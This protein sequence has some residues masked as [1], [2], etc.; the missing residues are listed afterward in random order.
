MNVL[1]ITNITGEFAQ[2]HG[3]NWP[4]RQLEFQTYTGAQHRMAGVVNVR[5]KIDLPKPFRSIVIGSDAGGVN[6][7]AR[8]DMAR[9]ENPVESDAVV[10]VY[11][12]PVSDVSVLLAGVQTHVKDGERLNAIIITQPVTDS[13]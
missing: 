2:G 12:V 8:I 13:Q 3:I 4:G 1:L 7:P 6:V 5:I 11:L 10:P 9:F